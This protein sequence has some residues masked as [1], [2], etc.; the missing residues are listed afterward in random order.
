MAEP[1][2]QEIAQ[3][4]KRLRSMGPN[5][6]CFDCAAKNPTWASVTY[7]IFICID[8]SAVHRSLGVHLSFVRSTQLDSWTWIQLRGMQVGGNTNAT[9]FFRQHGCTTK[10][11]HTKYDSRAAQLYR[12]KLSSKAAAAQTQYKTQLHIET[13]SEET[14]EEDFF[15]MV[16]Q[17][18]PDALD[19]D[20]S[21]VSLSSVPMAM[22]PRT[23]P[24]NGSGDN[25]DSRQPNVGTLQ[26]PTNPNTP[27]P[28]PVSHEPKSSL[29]GKRKAPAKKL[30]AKKGLGGQKITKSFSEI[31]QQIEQEEKMKH[32]SSGMSAPEP[33]GTEERSARLEYR[34]DTRSMDPQKAKQAERLGMGVASR[35]GVGHS[36]SSNMGTINQ[37]G[38][39]KSGRGQRTD[40]GGV[41]YD[42]NDSYGSS[43]YDPPGYTSHDSGYTSRDLG[44]RSSYTEQRPSN[45][46]SA[47]GGGWEDKSSSSSKDGGS[48]WGSSSSSSKVSGGGGGSTWGS[49]S[50]SSKVSGG[51]GGSTWA[52][53]TSSADSAQQRFSSA[54]SISSDQYFGR[55]SGGSLGDGGAEAGKFSGAS[56]ISSD[57]Y[58][59]RSTKTSGGGQGEELRS[60]I[61]SKI[62]TVASN[63]METIQDRYHGYRN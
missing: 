2:K 30:G 58:F 56:G 18:Q 19:L 20:K 10:E 46:H 13:Q 44:T 61:S 6:L 25:V 52:T 9:V 39:T 35:A 26:S 15:S 60:K 8:C 55:D 51:G 28:L 38:P 23:G 37:V 50:S 62:S 21:A 34:M 36:A 47:F 42:R 7:G 24:K 63:V 1:T 54:K 33:R 49:S 32:A 11:A 57:D 3:V 17:P 48:T 53:S 22:Q 5:K 4:F 31:E 41:S 29:I 59:G 40:K 16:L 14:K 45:K 27:H 12:D 43:S